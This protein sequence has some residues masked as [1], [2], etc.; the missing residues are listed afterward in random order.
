[1]DISQKALEIIISDSREAEALKLLNLV[2][3]MVANGFNILDMQMSLY[4]NWNY[5]FQINVKKGGC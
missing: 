5:Q 3:D 2:N 4:D 1:M